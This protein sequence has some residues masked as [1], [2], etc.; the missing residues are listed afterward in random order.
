MQKRPVAYQLYSARE[1]AQKVWTLCWRLAAMGYD[2]VEFAG[3]YGHSAEDVAAM[4][5]KYRLQ[6]VSSHVPVMRI[7]EDMFGR[8]RRAA[9]ARLPVSGRALPG[10][11]D[12]AGR[13]GICARAAHGVPLR[14]PV[15]GGGYP[16]ALP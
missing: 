5:Q 4:L 13:A 9:P 16:A 3:L 12:A 15:P 10:R 14:Q 1:D 7:E 11:D 8:H 2:G 6:A